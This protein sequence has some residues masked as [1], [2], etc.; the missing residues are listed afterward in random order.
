ML[1]L[2]FIPPPYVMS[3]FNL[4]CAGR[5]KFKLEGEKGEIKLQIILSDMYP[6]SRII[7]PVSKEAHAC[8]PGVF[9]Q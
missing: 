2:F 6:S 3:T 7:Q 4:V 8:E 1:V 5:D 9:S